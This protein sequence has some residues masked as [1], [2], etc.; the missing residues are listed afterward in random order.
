MIDTCIDI[1]KTKLIELL[2]KDNIRVRQKL[3]MRI[4]EN[5]IVEIEVS[6]KG[7]STIYN[8]D[9]LVSN[10]I[11]L[12]EINIEDLNDNIIDPDTLQNKLTHENAWKFY[13]FNKKRKI[14]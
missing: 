2:N 13:K 10:I 8:L 6:F 1:N 14:L 3:G 9:M 11:K 5:G 7:E 12:I 4:P